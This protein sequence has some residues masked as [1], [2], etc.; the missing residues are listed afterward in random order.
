MRVFIGFL[1]LIVT[2]LIGIG[3]SS[4]PGS[5]VV[6]KDKSQIVLHPNLNSLSFNSTLINKSDH[7]YESFYVKFIIQDKK[8]KEILGQSDV[9]IGEGLY[10]EG[11]STI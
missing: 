5:I 11:C 7:D 9:V 2:M 1:Y 10:E 3:C 8:L 4:E 6:V